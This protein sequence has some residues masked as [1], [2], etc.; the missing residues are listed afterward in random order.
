MDQMVKAI[1]TSDYNNSSAVEKLLKLVQYLSRLLNRSK[2]R[3]SLRLLYNNLSITRR[4]LRLFK[5]INVMVSIIK[6][7]KHNKITGKNIFRLSYLILL[8]IFLNLDGVILACKIGYIK[9]QRFISKLFTV[10]DFL[11]IAQNALSLIDHSIALSDI[12][13]DDSD[14]DRKV[15]HIHHD[16]VKRVADTGSALCFYFSTFGELFLSLNGIFSAF[17]GLSLNRG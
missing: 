1:W 9:D 10:V 11:W 7:V 14:A 5:Q 3:N 15:F 4:T 2:K 13:E 12:T 8:F 16:M 17:L 6:L